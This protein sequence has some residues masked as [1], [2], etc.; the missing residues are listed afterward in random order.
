[1]FVCERE[2]ACVRLCVYVCEKKRIFVCLRV[3]EGVLE[4]CACVCVN[5]DCVCVCIREWVIG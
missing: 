5:E 2:R 1:M 3:R 4:V